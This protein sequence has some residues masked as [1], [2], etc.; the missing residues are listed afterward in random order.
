MLVVLG[1]VQM[2]ILAHLLA[3]FVRVDQLLELRWQHHDRGAD[4]EDHEHL[5]DDVL[6]LVVAIADW[7]K[8]SEVSVSSDDAF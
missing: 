1:E 3:L 4:H 2:K 6:R 8:V 5:R 7:S